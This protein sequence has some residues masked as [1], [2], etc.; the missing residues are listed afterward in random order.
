M[1]SGYHLKESKVPKTVFPWLG[2]R[3]SRES[4]KFRDR[5]FVLESLPHSYQ[6]CD[7][8]QVTNRLCES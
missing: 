5:D 6:L 7:L 3:R 8:E 4:S 1:Y 2:E